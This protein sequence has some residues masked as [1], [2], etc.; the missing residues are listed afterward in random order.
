MA[1]S[2][3]LAVGPRALPEH[4]TVRVWV[5]AGSGGVGQTITVS[6]GD[7]Q[8]AERDSGEGRSALYT[9]RPHHG[10]E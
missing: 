7:L 1:H 2:E 10:R 5:D 9:L 4:G 3:I 8:V 6:V